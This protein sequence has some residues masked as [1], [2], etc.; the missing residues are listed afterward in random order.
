[1]SIWLSV[2]LCALL[3]YLLGCINPAYLI[4]YPKPRLR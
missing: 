2:I 4:R 3:G 1:M